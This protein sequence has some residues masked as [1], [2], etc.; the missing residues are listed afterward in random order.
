VASIAE[1]EIAGYERDGVVCLRGVIDSHWLEILRVATDEAMAAPGPNAE[2]YGDKEKRSFYG[3]LDV[4]TRT[5]GFRS[6]VLQSPAAE[7][8]ATVMQSAK[9]TLLYDQLLVKEKASQEKTPWHQ[10]QP[11]W[12]VKGRQIC[13]IWVPMDPIN[14]ASSPEY[15][16]GSHQWEEFNPQHFD[17]HS[18]Y[19]GTGLP[20]LPDIDAGRDSF[21]IMRFAMEPGDCLVF[22]AMIVHGAPG[23]S[24]TMHRRRGYASRWLG[25]DARYC[26]RLGEVAIP[27]FPTKLEDGDEFTGDMFPTVYRR[28]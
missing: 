12:A 15:I 9:A 23:N 14:E 17:D 2:F 21:D 20:P 13:S 7:I 3:D 22:Q 19:E 6:F 5:P 4:W 25:D 28:S 26:E 24:S 8:A 18:A 16:G 11:Y 1:S 10:D 27:T